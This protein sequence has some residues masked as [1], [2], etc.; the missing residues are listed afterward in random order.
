LEPLFRL[1]NDEEIQA[2]EVLGKAMRFGAMLAVGN[3][4]RAGVLK[5]SAKERLLELALTQ[6]GRDLFGEVAEARFTSLALSLRAETRVT[7]KP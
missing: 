3:P 5:W 2:A 1:L 7:D 4:G 6:F